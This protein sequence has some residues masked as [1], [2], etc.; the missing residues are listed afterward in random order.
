MGQ[1]TY[2]TLYTEAIFS[3]SSLPKD[4]VPSRISLM[5]ANEPGASLQGYMGRNVSLSMEVSFF[6]ICHFNKRH[7]MVPKNGMNYNPA[8][9]QAGNL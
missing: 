4:E 1:Y 7:C 8:Y 3:L 5:G 2:G 9:R 6:A